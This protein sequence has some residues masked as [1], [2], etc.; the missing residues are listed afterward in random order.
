VRVYAAT[1]MSLALA[2]AMLHL[3][4]QA[5]PA[6]PKLLDLGLGE[7]VAELGVRWAWLWLF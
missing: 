7:L 3:A 6:N 5:V 2:V 4:L 1:V